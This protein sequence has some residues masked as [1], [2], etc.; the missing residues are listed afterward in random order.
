ME[1]QRKEKRRLD[2]G[3]KRRGRGNKQE[4]RRANMRGEKPIQE[5]G[6]KDGGAV[7]GRRRGGEQRDVRTL[8]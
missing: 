8:Q 5:P 7:E 2:K 4:K 3:Q 1:R 6:E